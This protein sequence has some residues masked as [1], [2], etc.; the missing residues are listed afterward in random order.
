MNKHED[1]ISV[2]EAKIALELSAQIERDTNAVIRP[3][4]WL[5]IFISFFY[6]MMTFSWAS[7][8]HE[9]LWMLGMIISTICFFLALAF[10]LYTSSLLGVKPKLV[11]KSISEF[12]FHLFSALFFG[13][14]F[15]LSRY[16]S[17]EDI[18]WASYLGGVI[19]AFVLG[20]L[21]HNYSTGDYTTAA[22]KL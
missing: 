6:G 19:N 10:Y 12:K 17:T 20:Y 15:M 18:F 13:F 21:I 16:F 11:P 8:R 1:K 2:A 22:E 9:N 3:P 4:I 5:T 14:T 7:T